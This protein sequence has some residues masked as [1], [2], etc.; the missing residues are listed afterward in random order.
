MNSLDEV[1]D[2]A[3]FTHRIGRRPMSIEEIER[4]PCDGA[5]LDPNGPDGSWLVDV[6][7][8]NR[9]NPGFRVRVEGV[10]KFLEIDTT[11]LPRDSVSV[12]S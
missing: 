5:V 4:G 8:P 10:G 1:P 9:A 12:S 2:A 11:R 6:G 7:E 3:W